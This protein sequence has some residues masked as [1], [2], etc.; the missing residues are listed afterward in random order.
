[1]Q[2]V[3]DLIK[4][5]LKLPKDAYIAVGTWPEDGIKITLRHFDSKYA[6]KEFDYFSLD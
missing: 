5:L 4:E 1:M 2:T 3:E 6:E